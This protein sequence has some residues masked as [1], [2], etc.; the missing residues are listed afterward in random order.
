MS[1]NAKTP[2]K[3]IVGLGNPGS[4][5]EQTRHNAGFWFIEDLANKYKA[6]LKLDKKFNS[7]VGRITSDGLDAY[8]L[9]PL[10][11]M[12]LS[13]Q[14]VQAFC[15]F[16]KIT[17]SEIL[18]AHDELD[19]PPGTVKIKQSGGSGGHNGLKDIIQKFGGNS[20]FNRLRIGIGHPRNSN[21]KQEVHNYVLAKP[22]VSDKN[23]IM[24]AIY[25]SY[26][27]IDNL[28]IGDIQKAMQNL[29]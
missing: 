21:N 6:N 22:S 15:K 3:L 23:L 29:H 28:L 12:N 2:I 1:K 7:I 11:Y 5:Y 10:T 14:A 9:M 27:Q 13:G 8:L 16:Y 19:H 20:N 17:P 18:I 26:T 4:E 24:T 25:N